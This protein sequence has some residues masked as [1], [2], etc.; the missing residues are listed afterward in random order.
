MKVLSEIEAVKKIKEGEPLIFQTD[1]LPAIGCIPEYSDIIYTIKRREKNKALILMG[2]NLGQL[3]EFVDKE[4]KKDFLSMADEYWPG[5]L[6][7]VVPIDR[8]VTFNFISANNTL[9]LRIPNS[10][11]AKSLINKTGPL[12]TSSANISGIKTSIKADQISMDLPC[13]DLLGPIPWKE[14]SGK[15]STILRWI[16]LG[17]WECLREGEISNIK[18]STT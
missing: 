11:M 16:S 17:K 8:K 6:T 1:T 2:A 7:L 12:A 4:A 3:I 18:T 15:A 13:I 5:A 14:C 9:G 10:S